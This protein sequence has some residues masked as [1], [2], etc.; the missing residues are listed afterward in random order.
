M[1]SRG[2]GGK[3]LSAVAVVAVVAAAAIGAWKTGSRDTSAAAEERSH[4]AARAHSSTTLA[5]E[6]SAEDVPVTAGTSE[7]LTSV[8]Q[9]A[10]ELLRVH[11]AA[12]GPQVATGAE[13][14]IDEAFEQAATVPGDATVAVMEWLR[15][16][17]R[18][19]VYDNPNRPIESLVQHIEL[20]T[21]TDA[22]LAEHLGPNWPAI[23]DTLATVAAI[24][25]DDYVAQVRRSPAMRAADALDIRTQLQEQAVESGLQEQWQRSQDLVAAYFEQCIT[26]A[27][28]RRNPNDPMDEYIRDWELAQALVRDAVA[29]AFFPDTAGADREQVANLARGLR[30]VQAPDEFDQDGSLTRTVRP[31]ENLH[32]EDAELV[33]AEEPFLEDE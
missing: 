3:T 14:S 12:W 25:F 11:G 20:I 28:M 6:S 1:Q 31:G 5:P 10:A 32:P 23:V 29:A 17:E 2:R 16:A 22:D 26:E 13:L 27:L 24:G 4:G 8:V 30:I 19:G 15:Q 9:R 21:I 18:D 33:E 7:R